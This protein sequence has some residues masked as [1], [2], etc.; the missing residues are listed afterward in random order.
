M[1]CSS[2]HYLGI[3]ANEIRTILLSIIENRLNVEIRSIR[4][5][6]NWE[7]EKNKKFNV[8]F[9]ISMSQKKIWNKLKI[10]NIKC[11]FWK[12]FF[13]N[14]CNFIFLKAIVGSKSYLIFQQYFIIYKVLYT[15]YVE[16]NILV[17]KFPS[18]LF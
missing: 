16:R 18:L 11:R 12:F 7:W 3:G 10:N 2:I 5:I 14:L 17:S 15:L 6:F 4:N 9:R 1:F 13:N 8:I